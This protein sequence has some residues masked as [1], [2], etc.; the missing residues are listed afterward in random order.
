[1]T[2]DLPAN[3]PDDY[4]DDYMEMPAP[5]LFVPAL[6][7]VVALVAGA[8]LGIVTLMATDPAAEADR[9]EEKAPGD[10]ERTP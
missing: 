1:M 3:F 9:Q 7:A 5:T 8:A 10:G 6:A 4:V 2:D